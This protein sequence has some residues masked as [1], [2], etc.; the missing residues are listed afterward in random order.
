MVASNET[1][2]TL[3]LKHAVFELQIWPLLTR[4]IHI[5]K[6]SIDGLTIQ[7]TQ[8][9]KDWIVAGINTSQYLKEDTAKNSEED[10]KT[11]KS[12]HSTDETISPWRLSLPSFSFTNSQLILQRQP[13]LNIPETSDVVTLSSLTIEDLSGKDIL[14]QTPEWQGNAGI[15]ALVNQARFTINSQFNYSSETISA[16]VQI[17]DTNLPLASFQHFIPAPY[18]EGKGAIDFDAGFSFS[19]ETRDDGL[20]FSLNDLEFST[21]LTDIIWKE[22]KQDDV[23]IDLQGFSFEAESLQLDLQNTQDPEFSGSNID[24]KS[25]QLDIRSTMEKRLIAWQSAELNKLSLSQ[26]GQVFELTLQQLMVNDVTLSQVLSNSAPETT[27]NSALPPLS[28]IANIQIDDIN[29]NQKGTSINS[30]AMNSSVVNLIISAQ[31]NFENLVVIESKQPELEPS[32]SSTTPKSQDAQKVIDSTQNAEQDPAFKAPYYVILNAFDLT[33]ESSI[34]VQD[35]STSP[36]LSRTLQI[37]TLSLRNL[38]TQDKEQATELTLKARN[39]KYSTLDSD[40]TIWP[41]ADELTLKSRLAIKEAELPPYSSYIANALGYQIDSGHLNLDLILNADNG[42]LDGNANILLREFDLGG[43]QDS[44]SVVKAGAIPLNIAVGILKD[45]NDNIKLDVPL[46]GDVDNPEFGWSDFLVLPFRKALYKVSSNYLLQTFVPYA[47]VISIVQF[48]GEQLLKVRVEP[49]IFT[50]QDSELNDSQ[51]IFLQQLTALMKDKK[52]SQLKACG[53]ASYKDLGLETPPL[54]VDEAM[55]STAIA[56]AQ[57]RA[58]NVKDYLVEQG[59][60]SSRI[61]LC[62]PKMDFSKN[63]QPR[64]ELNF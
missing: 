45:S 23:Y 7:V 50:A 33:G 47:N 63:S 55:T 16:D 35:K 52:D 32:L 37:D 61:L 46:S 24:I 39:G 9:E 5:S 64:T 8:R 19:Q 6:A 59:I 44:S 26:Q 54:S 21:K 60:D 13:D 22:D 57:L 31:K 43:R 2:D 38:N 30:I 29:A 49:L 12:K 18:N 62:S 41:L 11:D 3:S 58:E 20:I 53:V 48:A 10:N 36:I 25:Q 42:V 27:Q 40:I 1:Q 51:N 56:I 28:R 34:S 14:S 15:S 17:E 4:T